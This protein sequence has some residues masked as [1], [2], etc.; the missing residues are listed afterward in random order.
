MD[1]AVTRDGLFAPT[2]RDRIA[3]RRRAEHQARAEARAEQQRKGAAEVKAFHERAV[4]NSTVTGRAAD[5]WRDEH[6]RG[7][8]P[9]A[10]AKEI[11]EFGS[12]DAVFGTF[13]TV[14]R[15]ISSEMHNTDAT[16]GG[17][18]TLYKAFSLFDA[19]GDGKLTEEEVVA[20]LTRK[21][22]MGSEFSEEVARH[23]WKR[24]QRKFDLN[25][26]GKISYKELVDD[27]QA[28]PVTWGVT[29]RDDTQE[30][31]PWKTW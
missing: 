29:R 6:S 9:F 26:D 10:T 13:A 20:V 3:A 8:P 25:N 24:W 14:Q 12:S 1:A 27:M 16:R 23:T 19:D 4:V 28:H 5:T 15:N 18:M 30:H 22:P 2:D 11:R 31:L 17:H 7:P 21:T